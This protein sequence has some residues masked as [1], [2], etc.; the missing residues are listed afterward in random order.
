VLVERADVSLVDLE[1]L[2]AMTAAVELGRGR[3]VGGGGQHPRQP[4]AG[5]VIRSGADLSYLP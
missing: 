5:L 1:V 4:G 2:G 3:R